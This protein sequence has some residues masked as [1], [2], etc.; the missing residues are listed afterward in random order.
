MTYYDQAK[1]FN[2][3]VHTSRNSLRK[4]NKY[5]VFSN[6]HFRFVLLVPSISDWTIPHELYTTL[7]YYTFPCLIVPPVVRLIKRPPRHVRICRLRLSDGQHVHRLW[8]P[9]WIIPSSNDYYRIRKAKCFPG[10]P[11]AFCK[12]SSNKAIVEILIILK[13]PITS[14]PDY[15]LR[16]LLRDDLENVFL[17]K[18]D[19]KR[20]NCK[21]DPNTTINE[22]RSVNLSTL[23]VT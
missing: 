4:F 16:K 2:Y 3:N 10:H 19:S 20:S 22:L 9:S 1:Y 11:V 8:C 17:V 13:S 7:M 5:S 6:W 15:V 12:M 18:F 23:S 21:F 14:L